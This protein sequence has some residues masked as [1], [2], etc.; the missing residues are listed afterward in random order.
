MTN[1]RV[2]LDVIQVAEPCHESWDAMTGDDRVRFCRGC[3]KHVHNLSAMS[4]T[5]AERLVC[6]SAGSLCVRFARGEDGRVQTLEYRA[7]T[8]RARGWRFWTTVSTCA[9]ALVAGVNGYLWAR[10]KPVPPAVTVMLGEPAVPAVMLG[11]PAA[12]VVG[13]GM[14]SAPP[15]PAACGNTP[16]PSVAEN[17]AQPTT[18]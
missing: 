11:K 6:E 3:S 9:A 13:M 16:N 18:P 2:S 8:R 5:E 10:G 15:L 14:F 17:T 1:Q 4:R 7:P 12:P